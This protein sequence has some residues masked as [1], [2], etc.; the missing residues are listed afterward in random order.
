[1]ALIVNHRTWYHM[2]GI[3]ELD[4][5]SG[6]IKLI[7]MQYTDIE[8][9]YLI[10]HKTHTV[11]IDENNIYEFKSYLGL[12]SLDISIDSLFKNH[13]PN[14]VI[15]SAFLTIYS[16]L[17]HNINFLCT[18]IEKSLK[19]KYSYIDLTGNGIERAVNYIEKETKIK[20]RGNSF[21][22][23]F[24]KLNIIRNIIVH[25][26]GSARDRKGK[27]L[28]KYKN[29]ESFKH[30]SIDSTITFKETFLDFLE[31][32]LKEFFSFLDTELNII[33]YDHNEDFKD[34]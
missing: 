19:S 32:F 2:F 29:L 23:D 31:V 11:E 4:I 22:S 28:S 34:C 17:E 6:F 5:I 21:W 7:K 9:R 13:Y 15:Q 18:V 25:N 26:G 20:I 10:E 16:D 8:K 12:D 27:L 33:P 14:L 3:G 24:N 1:M 30:I